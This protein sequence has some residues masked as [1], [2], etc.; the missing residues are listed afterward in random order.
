MNYQKIILAGNISTDAKMRKSKKG[1]ISYLSFGVGV[2]NGRDRATF[3]PIVA[4]GKLGEM[5]APH[6]AKGHQVLVEGRVEINNGFTN[7]IADR[8][9]LGVL[10][11][12]PAPVEKAEKAK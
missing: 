9:V 12:I 4:F 1:D 6:I 10:P 5:F 8:L 3:F 11:K 7:V 2:M